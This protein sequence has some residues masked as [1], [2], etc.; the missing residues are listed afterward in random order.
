M[1]TLSDD[2]F[3]T[4]FL[5]PKFPEPFNPEDAVDYVA[6][7]LRRAFSTL[8]DTGVDPSLMFGNIKMIRIPDVVCEGNQ[9]LLNLYLPKP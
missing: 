5:S 9:V 7:A 6:E 3:T 2:L 4:R 8:A 1:S